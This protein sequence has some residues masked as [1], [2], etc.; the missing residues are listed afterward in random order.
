M[1]SDI[2]ILLR[3]YKNAFGKVGEGIHSYRAFDIAYLDL[4]VT[5]VAAWGFSKLFR[6]N[7]WITVLGLF[8]LGIIIHRLFGVRTTIDKMIW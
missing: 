1:L 5:F 7:L 6:L 2:Q 8:L 4:G 3:P